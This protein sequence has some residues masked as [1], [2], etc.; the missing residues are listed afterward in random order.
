MK[1]AHFS[2]LHLCSEFGGIAQVN[3]VLDA[4]ADA[5]ERGA[6]HFVFT[7]DMVEHANLDDFTPVINGLEKLGFTSSKHITIVPGNHDVVPW[8]W[9]AFN[10]SF[11]TINSA[12]K[13]VLESLLPLLS[14]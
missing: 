4:I 3:A 7:G 1:I 9:G 8:S 5:S 14:E 2:D 12:R 11:E 10:F 6:E 13:K